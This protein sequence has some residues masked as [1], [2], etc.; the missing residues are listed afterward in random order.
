MT[1]D[2]KTE[3]VLQSVTGET[4]EQR[5]ANARAMLGQILAQK[6]FWTKYQVAFFDVRVFDPNAK[7]YSSQSLQRCYVDNKQEKKSQYKMRVLQVENGSFTPFPFSINGGMGR[8][9]LKFYS[10][11]TEMLPQKCDK[12][13]RKHC[14]GFEGNYHF[15]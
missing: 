2:V 6:G 14:H 11:I 9:G 8:G 5:T 7:R 1:K 4:F 13:T 3:P 15:S 12:L 10:R